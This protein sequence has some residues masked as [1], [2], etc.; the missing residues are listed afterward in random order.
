LGTTLGPIS[1]KKEH[2]FFKINLENDLLK[3]FNFSKQVNND[4]KVKTNYNMEDAWKISKDDSTRNVA[5][6]SWHITYNI[7]DY[8]NEEIQKLK[9]GITNMV[10][11]A[12]DYYGIDAKEQQY[13]LKGHLNYYAG[14]KTINWD[15]VAW[16]NHGDN[17]LE[18]HGYYCI[19]AE[20]SVTYYQVDEKIV[21]NKNKNNVAILSQ[22]GYHHSVGDW[23]SEDVR[24]TIGYNVF[25]LKNI[26]Q[27]PEIIPAGTV[28]YGWDPNKKEYTTTTLS[29]PISF[30]QWIPLEI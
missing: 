17:P 9:S 26:T 19:N 28:I 29:D 22:N 27:S 6:D 13:M 11:E 21:E 30:G 3:M 25:P 18:F 7:F 24:I 2:K 15:N 4:L 10:I 23:L 20:P 14:P 8:A 5:M 16:D 12:C 1:M